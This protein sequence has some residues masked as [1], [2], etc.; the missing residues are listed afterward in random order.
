MASNTCCFCGIVGSQP[1]NNELTS[2]N[3]SCLEIRKKDVKRK[4]KKDFALST[5]PEVKS[6]R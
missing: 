6:I 4:K 3:Y 5:D 2:F 1:I